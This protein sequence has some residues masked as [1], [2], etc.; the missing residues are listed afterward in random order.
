MK[1]GHTYGS[2]SISGRLSHRSRCQQFERVG[3]IQREIMPD[4]VRNIY[5]P[6]AGNRDIPV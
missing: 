5:Q 6:T 3:D 4:G 2:L 1:G